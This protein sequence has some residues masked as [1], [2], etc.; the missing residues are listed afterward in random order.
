MIVATVAGGLW[1]AFTDTPKKKEEKRWR[2]GLLDDL[3]DID[4]D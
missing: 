2:R 3:D 1:I 4:F